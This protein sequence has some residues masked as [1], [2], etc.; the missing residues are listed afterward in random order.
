MPHRCSDTQPSLVSLA[1]DLYR[2]D[3]AIRKD[4]LKVMTALRAPLPVGDAR[5]PDGPLEEAACLPLVVLQV[6]VPS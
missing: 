2:C 4:C 1:S 3:P 6:V 5:L